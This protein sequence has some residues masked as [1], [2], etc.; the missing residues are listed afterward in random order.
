[1][2]AGARSI[3]EWKTMK[4]ITPHTAMDAAT[5]IP[6]QFFASN[7]TGTQSIPIEVSG[8]L[9]ARAVAASI[10][11]RMALPDDV[12]WALRDDDSSAYL[13]ESRSIGEQILPGSR[14]T[15]TPLTHL[16]GSLR[17]RG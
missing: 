4:E 17:S 8:A 13:D 12:A 2:A 3:E 10:A 7:V 9:S 6:I 15:V 1:M 5:A 16:G 14:V 11:D